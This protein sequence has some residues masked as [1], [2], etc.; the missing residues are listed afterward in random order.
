MI[1]LAPLEYLA[2]QEEIDPVRMLSLS[3]HWISCV[4]VPTCHPAVIRHRLGLHTD[5]LLW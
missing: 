2:L 1:F 3:H 4:P 5:F